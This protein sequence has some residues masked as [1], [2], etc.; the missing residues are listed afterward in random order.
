MASTI[1]AGNATNGLALSCDNTGILELKTGTGAGT[2]A[3]TIDASQVASF[4]GNVGIGT[5]SPGSRMHL[6]GN[7]G[8][9]PAMLK[10]TNTTAS[11]TRNIAVNNSNQL[12]FERA[13]VA[14][15]ALIDSSGNFAIPTSYSHTTASAANTFMRSDGYLQRSTSAL[16]Y[17]QDIRNLQSIDISLLRPVRYKSKCEGDDQTK[18]HL[19]IVADEAHESGFTELVTY[20]AEG[21]VEGFQYE[22]LTVVL[23]KELQEQQ[24]MIEELK[25]KVAALEGA[26]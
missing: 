23:L 17:K 10:I 15:D 25:A 3:L 12:V 24:A 13:G 6:S 16:K 9:G 2:T 14:T 4:A 22:R 18:D 11:A 7:D 21:E 8:T 1:T 20:G 5:S 26:A 19:G